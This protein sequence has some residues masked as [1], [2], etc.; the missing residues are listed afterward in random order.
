MS[1]YYVT[2]HTGLDETTVHFRRSSLEPNPRV[3]VKRIEQAI[4]DAL[5]KEFMEKHGENILTAI[6]VSDISRGVSE[7][8]SEE[9]QKQ[10]FKGE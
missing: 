9:I 7:A 4:L 3:I 6:H 8:I 2:N 1:E 10:F 5:V